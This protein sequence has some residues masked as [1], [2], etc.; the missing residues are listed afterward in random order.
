MASIDLSVDISLSSA[1]SYLYTSAW[2]DLTGYD[3]LSVI[4]LS[5]SQNC[6][7]FVD[8]G[9]SNS[10]TTYTSVA[11]DITQNS[12][13]QKTFTLLG[14][15][16]RIRVQGTQ[17]TTASLQTRLDSSAGPGSIAVTSLPPV[18]NTVNTT[19]YS[20]NT[21]NTLQLASAVKTRLRFVHA[22]NTSQLI[23]Y[24]HIWDA[25]S[26]GAV[27]VGTTVPKIVLPIQP[28][29]VLSAEIGVG[30][31][32]GLVYCAMTSPG[33]S[34]QQSPVPGLLTTLILNSDTF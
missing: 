16:Y 29:G 9:T 31:T 33:I 22:A 3:G 18:T 8:Y 14:S 2:R 1:N 28:A 32:N 30:F 5:P 6:S 21:T 19:Y 26:T 27:M 13:F 4:L 11:I 10:P 17:T 7:L 23:A 25:S 24:L 15:W 12:P 34:A 20:A